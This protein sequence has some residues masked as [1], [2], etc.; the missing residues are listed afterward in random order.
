MGVGIQ[1]C[2]MPY[3]LG[4]VKNKVRHLSQVHHITDKAQIR[5][6]L[7]GTDA[8][9]SVVRPKTEK[10][11]PMCHK[12]FKRLDSHLVHKHHFKRG[13]TRF[14]GLLQSLEAD[15]PSQQ[16]RNISSKDGASKVK[17]SGARE[18]IDLYKLHFTETSVLSGSSIEI[19]TRLLADR[20]KY[21]FKEGHKDALTGK[22]LWKPS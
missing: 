11:C 20:I 19:S 12:N 10:R 13:S 3:C 7:M 17:T 18:L 21:S 9:K 1:Q 6:M 15:V 4:T 8:P 2:P 16:D 5:A 22:S 14:R